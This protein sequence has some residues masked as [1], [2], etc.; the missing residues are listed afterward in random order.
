MRA[1]EV[2]AGW[3]AVQCLRCREFLAVPRDASTADRR[4]LI[5]DHHGW[6]CVCPTANVARVRADVRRARGG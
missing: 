4:Q 2:P 5:A 1:D 6:L 3:L